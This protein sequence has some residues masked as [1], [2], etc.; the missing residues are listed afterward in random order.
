MG[1][2]DDSTDKSI[3]KQLNELASSNGVLVVD[4]GNRDYIIKH[5]E[6]VGIFEFD[7][8]E[9]HDHRRLNLEESRAE[10]TWEFYKKHREGL[11]LV[12]AFSSICRLY[13]L[14]ELV[15]LLET[16]GWNYCNSYGNFNLEPVTADT[17][18]IIIVGKKI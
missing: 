18:R 3:V 13:N 1:Y 15:R 17:S 14:D 9:V 5:H 16:T 11:K 2:Y 10:S 7:G 12:A 6:P 4:V 8:Y